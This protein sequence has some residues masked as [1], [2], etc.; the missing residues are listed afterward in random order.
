MQGGNGVSWLARFCLPFWFSWVVLASLESDLMID[1]L[2]NE[3]KMDQECTGLWETYGW[4]I[5]Y[6][7]LEIW[8]IQRLDLNHIDD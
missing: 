8:Q 7:S 1:E 2:L 5:S 4:D 3:W 6:F